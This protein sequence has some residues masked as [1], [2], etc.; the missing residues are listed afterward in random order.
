M[1][2]PNPAQFGRHAGD[3]DAV[4]DPADPRA[5][6]VPAPIPMAPK[7]PDFRGRE[8]AE[9]R[10]LAKGEP[11][12][13]D[14]EIR[15]GMWGRPPG[16][17]SG[18]PRTGQRLRFVRDEW[19]EV[20]M[21]TVLEVQDPADGD[22]NLRMPWHDAQGRPQWNVAGDPAPWVLLQT[23]DGFVTRCREARVRGAAGWLPL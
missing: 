19:G 1:P 12:R 3:G 9:V 7:W 23:D 6:P 14:H 10:R 5:L 21:A 18:W 20:E 22:P 2:G 15:T 11:T 13:S 8:G 4:T 17:Q 16:Q